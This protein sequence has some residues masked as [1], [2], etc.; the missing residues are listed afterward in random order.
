MSRTAADPRRSPAWADGVAAAE[1]AP[2]DARQL[3]LARG[4]RVAAVLAVEGDLLEARDLALPGAA[5]L[6][7]LRQPGDQLPDPVAKLE[8]EVGGGGAHEL[9][10]VLHGRLPPGL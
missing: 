8:R 2:L 4:A 7:V 9:V 5:D 1:L 6:V 10:Q 3:A